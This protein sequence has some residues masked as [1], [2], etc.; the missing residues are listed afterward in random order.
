MDRSIYHSLW[1]QWAIWLVSISIWLAHP[2]KRHCLSYHGASYRQ[3]WWLCRLPRL[4]RVS[5]WLCITTLYY[6]RRLHQNSNSQ[7]GCLS[8]ACYAYCKGMR[9]LERQ[10]YLTQKW[11]SADFNTD[12]IRCYFSGIQLNNFLLRDRTKQPVS[13]LWPTCD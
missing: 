7:C 6:L 9:L 8:R 11:V 1:L 3:D 10:S 4:A 13:R 5:W 2:N 12:H